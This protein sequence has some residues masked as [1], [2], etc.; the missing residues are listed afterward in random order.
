MTPDEM[1][2]LLSRGVSAWE[3]SVRK[4]QD[5]ED[6][7]GYDLGRENCAIC[8]SHN[9]NTPLFPLDCEGCVIDFYTGDGCYGTPWEAWHEHHLKVH[10]L[11]LKKRVRCTICGELARTQ[12]EYLKIMRKLETGR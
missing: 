2:L 1:L 8:H 9:I 11:V 12:K 5:I 10:G 6:R 3:V 4:W 7:K